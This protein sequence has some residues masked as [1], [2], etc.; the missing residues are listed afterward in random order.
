M[1]YLMI[2]TDMPQHGKLSIFVPIIVGRIPI[3]HQ[4]RLPLLLMLHLKGRHLQH[5]IH[6]TLHLI[7]ETHLQMNLPLE[8]LLELWLRSA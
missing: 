1:S 4:Q 2:L 8:Q 5:L 6:R 3:K 7:K